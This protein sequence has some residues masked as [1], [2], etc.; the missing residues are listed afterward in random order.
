AKPV[1]DTCDNG[2]Y[3][4]PLDPKD[5]VDVID[6]PYLPF[7]PGMR[8]VYKGQEEGTPEVD[9]VDVTNDRHQVMGV[10]AV[11]VHDVVTVHGEVTENTFDWYTQDTKGNVW[12]LGEDTAEYEH[13]KVTTR[14]G[15]WEWGVHGAQPGIAMPAHPKPGQKYRQEYDRGTAE[16]VA[17][18]L[19]TTGRVRV[20]TGTYS[21]VVV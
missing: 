2:E 8:W 18:V 7:E 10:S 1:I 4:A 19:R 14:E 5:A 3:H 13:G 12:Y 20:R 6:N 16:D 9:T 21:P 11:V 15:S 17:L